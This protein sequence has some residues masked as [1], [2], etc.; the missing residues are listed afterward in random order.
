MGCAVEASY[1]QSTREYQPSR[2]L[3]AL[4]D[5]DID[6]AASHGD[7]ATP[8]CS[9]VLR[10]LQA[11]RI[12]QMPCADVFRHSQPSYRSLLIHIVETLAANFTQRTP[13]HGPDE[14]RFVDETTATP[15]SQESSPRYSSAQGSSFVSNPARGSS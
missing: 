2:F 12:S 13:K 3:V 1:T 7:K 4:H 11:R 8:L 14:V 10:E 6:E 5:T 9:E 15:S